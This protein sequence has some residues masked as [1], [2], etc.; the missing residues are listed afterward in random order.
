MYIQT[1]STDFVFSAADAEEKWS[2]MVTM[3]RLFDFKEKGA[4][5][6]NNMDM[7]RSQGF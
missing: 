6:Y 4:S 5:I 3:E 2:W 7:I 1:K